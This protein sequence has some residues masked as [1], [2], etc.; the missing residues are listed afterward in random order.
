MQWRYI[1]FRHYNPYT[2]T[3][4]NEAVLDSVST[5][6]DPTVFLAGWRPKCINI[7][8]SQKVEEEV[9]MEEFRER[10]AVIVRRQGGGG[11]TY[12]TEN[13]EITWHI[14]APEEYFPEDVNQVYEDVCG[15]IASGLESIGIDARHEPIND[16]VTENGKISGATLKRN[17]N[18]VYVAGTLLYEVDAEEMFS[19]LTPGEDKLKGKAIDDFRDR[20]TSVSRESDASFEEAKDALKSALLQN[21]NFR[22]TSW[23]QEEMEKAEELAEKYR[24]EEWIYQ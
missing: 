10:D 20:V 4:L 13:G 17:G 8:R 2:K 22:Q 15:R 6:N 23:R 9:D 19:L 24:K 12:L 5:G 16:I 7:G 21:K 18:T 3:G 14:V 11:T 1:P